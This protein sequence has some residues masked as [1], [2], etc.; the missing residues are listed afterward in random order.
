MEGASSGRSKRRKSRN[1]GTVRISKATACLLCVGKSLYCSSFLSPVLHPTGTSGRL[2]QSAVGSMDSSPAEGP[3]VPP[4]AVQTWTYFIREKL[5]G[6]GYTW[7]PLTL[8]AQ[9]PA[10][11][12]DFLRTL[13][14]AQ[15]QGA[16]HPR[17]PNQPPLLCWFPEHCGRGGMV[18]HAWVPIKLYV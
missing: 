3:G 7:G 9:A 2:S 15:G 1:C 17:P 12:R 4:P 16:T 6:P 18:E 5:L 10:Q 8:A 13:A 14:C 11:T